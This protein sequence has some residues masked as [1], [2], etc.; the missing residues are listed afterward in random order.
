MNTPFIFE[1][2]SIRNITCPDDKAS[3]RAIY[4]GKAPIASFLEIP[5]DE[6]VREY[7]VEAQG[8]KKRS[9][10]QVHLRIRDTLRNRPQDFCVLNN[11]IT[12]IARSIEIDDQK[13][14]ARINLPSI[15]NGSQTQGEL[16]RFHEEDPNQT[17]F[18]TF[19]IVVCDDDD[20]IADISIARNFQN[21]V[22]ALSIAGRLGQFD[23][24][25]ERI[26]SVD[27]TLRLKKSETDRSDDFM[28]SEKLI[29]V[30]TALIPT[31]LWPRKEESPNKAVAYSGKAQC[32]KQFSSTY[33]K[34]KEHAS[35]DP[36]AVEL[37]R[38]FLDVA[39]DA[40]NLYAEWKSNQA[41]RGTG[42]RSIER[43]E[44]GRILDV[45]DGIVFPIIA[46]YSVFV[47]R[48]GDGWKL[49]VPQTL[50][51]AEMA[52]IAKV[53]YMEIAGSN[54]GTMGKSRACYSQLLQYTSLLK[55]L[56]TKIV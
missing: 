33:E 26:Q 23:E 14:I 52:Q 16:R 8:K 44:D 51:H 41:F 40:W 49:S 38:F 6:N 15:I 45:P 22:A 29:Q 28:D 32:L 53:A 18:V 42:L 50:E 13:K 2:N 24:L 55:R 9:P 31:D 46:A 3:E 21:D 48:S 36:R 54:P 20:L 43:E 27:H 37:Y 30:L 34:A 56:S 4:A 17:V 25:E 19:E 7:L 11:G 1:Y 12:L 47:E 39:V 10:S 35:Q 5:D